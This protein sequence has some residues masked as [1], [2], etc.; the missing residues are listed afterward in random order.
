MT[1]R[2]RFLVSTLVTIVSVVALMGWTLFELRQIQSYN[3]D[4]GKQLVEI[5]E[6]E[7]KLLYEQA[8]WN[9]LASQP[10]ENQ[11]EQ[12]LA[13]SKKNEKA[14]DSL[15]KTYL[16][17]R[18]KP[19]LNR[20]K[21]KYTTLA[22]KR[23]TLLNE[24]D[25][26][27]IRSHAAQVEGVLSDLYTLH[28][29]NGEFYDV[30]QQEAK[31]K[32]LNLT[33]SVLI[34]T[35]ILLIALAL[36]NWYF[37]RSITRPISRVVQTAEQISQGDVSQQLQIS[38][39]TDEIGRLESAIAQMQGTLHGVI[40]TISQ[41]STTINQMSEQ[42]TAENA[43]IVEVS[44]NMTHAINEMA[45]GTQ[46]VSDDL[47]TT[48]STITDM[49]TLFEQ[50]EQRAQQALSQGQLA[51]TTMGKSATIMQEQAESLAAAT[52]QNQELGRK[53][54]GFLQQTQQIEQMA[55][56]VSSVSAQTNLLSLNAA[57]E[58]ARAG[59]AGRGFAV[60]AS[61]VKKLA[62]ETHQATRSIFSLV[63]SIRA[64]GAIL[65]EALLQSEKEQA[66]Q[67]QNFAEVT[68]S[69]EETRG[70]VTDV[71][72]A[73]QFM[74]TQLLQ[75][76]D[77]ANQVVNQVS[78]VSGVMEELAAGNEEVAASMRDQQASFEQIHQLMLELEQTTTSL[79]QQTSQFKL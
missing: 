1:L 5:S 11:K 21:M 51:D 52:L 63:R 67:V 43:N 47:Q 29:K 61:E 74:T 4:Y 60:V 15:Q 55:Q 56:L 13:L 62:D 30:L 69:F 72:E 75:S 40:G 23:T 73:V 36:Y 27:A 79:D 48:V 50:S 25:P 58:A 49:S 31:D 22:E 17:D 26:I 32:T 24:L 33:R 12:A 10:S 54:A 18:F 77:Q 39:R 59:E 8:A 3:E 7:T 34:A 42:A 19:D 9:R 16:I 76:K 28:T 35:F 37:A 20:A 44:G 68:S 70:H 41:T 46:T 65:Q 45:S 2:Q 57:I 53:L 66:H 78:S 14:L 38:G 71:T 64:D 6:L